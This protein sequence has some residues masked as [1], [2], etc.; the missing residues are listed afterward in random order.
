MILLVVVAA[1]LGTVATAAARSRRTVESAPP[2]GPR[3]LPPLNHP[4]FESIVL[5]PDQRKSVD[6]IRAAFSVE[7]HEILVTLAPSLAQSREAR[8]RHDTL[9]MKRAVEDAAPQ[10]AKLSDLLTRER[11]ALRAVLSPEQQTVF[12][13]NLAALTAREAKARAE[14]R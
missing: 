7:A 1:P 13:R 11:M 8:A 6:S 12:D 14:S 3:T 10:R 9:A 5:A 2:I 4:L